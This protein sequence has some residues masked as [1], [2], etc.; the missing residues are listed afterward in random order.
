MNPPKDFI[1]ALGHRGRLKPYVLA[2][3]YVE[4]PL[5]VNGRKF[6]LRVW[7]RNKGTSRDG[8][9]QVRPRTDR[10]STPRV[11]AAL[12][13]RD[14]QRGMRRASLSYGLC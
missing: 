9:A 5:L 12:L 1:L 8:Q 2:Q 4:R 11:R 3:R 10:S 7:V 13:L 6:G 14:E